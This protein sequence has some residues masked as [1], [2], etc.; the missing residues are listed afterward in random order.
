MDNYE[1][2]WYM[3]ELG[4]HGFGAFREFKALE[5][6]IAN[7]G[8]I[9]T[10]VVWF[11]LTSFLAHA[12]MISKYLFPIKP[13]GIKQ[14]RMQVL[15]D[16]LGID[17]RSAILSRDARDNV[18]HFDERIDNWVENGGGAILE[19]VIPNRRGYDYLRAGEK[20][21]KRLLLAEEMIFISER[22][23][24]SQLELPLE[25]LIAEAQRIGK[26]AN[27]WIGEESTYHAIY[28]R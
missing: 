12:A 18:E 6:A 21:I 22:R 19:A 3:E 1:I 5:T 17:D 8:T 10:R 26:E 2:T 13:R 28:P 15:R 7:P 25:P 16:Q 4:M 23:D 14:T 9:N 24:G 27:R 20:R 11:H